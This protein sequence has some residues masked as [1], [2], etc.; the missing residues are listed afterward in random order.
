VS[1]IIPTF[2]QADYLR[3]AL[4]SLLQQTYTSWEAIIVNNFSTDRTVEVI[5]SMNDPRMTWTNFANDGV[6]AKSRN[7]AL[8]KCN[9]QFIAFLDSDDLWE[10]SK[11]ERAIM[12]L[13]AGS[14][15]VCHAERWFGGGSRD[16]IVRYGPSSRAT[17]ESLLLNGNCISTSAVVMRH[18][19]LDQL[20]GFR[21][22]PNFVTTEDYDLWLRVAQGGFTISFIDEVLG[23]FRRHKASA[24]SAPIR[25][26]NAELSVIDDH[27]RARLPQA[28]KEHKR[29]RAL[30][31]Y[32]AARTFSKDGRKLDGFRMFASS[33]KLSP[34]KARTWAGLG[35][36]L[37]SSIPNPLNWTRRD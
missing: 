25:H 6:I 5:E 27:F 29:R 11:L 23:S 24:S 1:V 35:V 28:L 37:I 2:N 18:E 31:Y 10:P 33:L 4:G 34:L 32:T 22:D 14:D 13:R 12:D 9:G 3:E 20:G 17:Y 21:D 7:R 26:L 36:H 19:V 30:A 15:L 16:R 8:S